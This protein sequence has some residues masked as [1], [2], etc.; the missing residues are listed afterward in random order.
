MF[1]FFGKDGCV[2]LMIKG[3]LKGSVIAL[4]LGF[5][6]YLGVFCW[7]AFVEGIRD[8][9]TMADI[10]R[11]RTAMYYSMPYTLASVLLACWFALRKQ[12][13]HHNFI[14]TG[15]VLLVGLSITAGPLKMALLH[16]NYIPI[17][18]AGLIAA[19]INKKCAV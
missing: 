13:E 19:Y 9:V 12:Q 18:L 17:V 11:S 2:N 4:L 3:I 6:G 8:S 7:L 15:I 5:A 1:N 16:M 14:I 10:I